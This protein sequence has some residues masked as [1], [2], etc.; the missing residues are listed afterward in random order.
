[1]FDGGRQARAYGRV[2][3]VEPGENLQVR[4]R[5]LE[6]DAEAGSARLFQDVVLSDEALRLYAPELSYNTSKRE[7]N[8]TQEPEWKTAALD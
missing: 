4:C 6:Y 8:Y 2:R 7:V 5:Y 1:M 3:I